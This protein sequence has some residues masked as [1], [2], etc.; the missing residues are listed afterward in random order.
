MSIP[1]AEAVKRLFP[2]I[3]T[4]LRLYKQAFSVMPGMNRLG[5]PFPL[6]KLNKIG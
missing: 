4:L 2:K 5:C 3:A 6:M 1:M